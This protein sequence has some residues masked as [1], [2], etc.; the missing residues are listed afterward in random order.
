M[1]EN[2]SSLI[3]NEKNEPDKQQY[4]IGKTVKG[5]KALIPAKNGKEESGLVVY[6]RKVEYRFN[7]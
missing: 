3:N 1:M 4:K 6:K 2:L 5:T 7:G